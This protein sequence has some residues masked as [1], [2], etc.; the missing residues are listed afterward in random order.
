MILASYDLKMPHRGDSICPMIHAIGG[1][2]WAGRGAKF[3]FGI[4]ENFRRCRAATNR[5][6][7]GESN[8]SSGLEKIPVDVVG[9]PNWAGDGPNF[10]SG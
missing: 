2:S 7:V 9:G 4:R 6:A 10:S 1:T 5:E 3:L 8:Y